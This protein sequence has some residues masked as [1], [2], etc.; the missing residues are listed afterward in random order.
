MARKKK[1]QRR[2]GPKAGY[3]SPGFPT[4]K[5]P[6]RKAIQDARKIAQEGVKP[7]A[8]EQ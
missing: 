7:V 1:K 6:G 4:V 5:Q 8:S 3:N 2:I